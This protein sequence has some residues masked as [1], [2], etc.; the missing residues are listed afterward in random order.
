MAKNLT[1][2]V[3]SIGANGPQV[4][5]LNPMCV[6]DFMPNITPP[7]TTLVV[8][9]YMNPFGVFQKVLPVQGLNFGVQAEMALEHVIAQCPDL[10]VQVHMFQRW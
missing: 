3:K 10:L 5:G 7:V 4:T 1:N 8:I 9:L 2:F 6:W